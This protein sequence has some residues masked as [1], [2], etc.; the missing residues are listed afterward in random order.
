MENMPGMAD[1]ICH[2]DWVKGCPIAN[3]ILLLGVS[4]RM[5]PGE[6]SI[7]T[8]ELSKADGPP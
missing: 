2:F 6:I 5:L 1:F 7:L 3:I 4:V 8:G